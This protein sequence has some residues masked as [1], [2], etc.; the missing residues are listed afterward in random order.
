MSNMWLVLQHFPDPKVRPFLYLQWK[1]PRIGMKGWF[2]LIFFMVFLST[3]AAFTAW[4]IWSRTSSSTE[5]KQEREKKQIEYSYIVYGLLV[6]IAFVGMYALNIRPMARFL[7]KCLVINRTIAVI[8]NGELCKE[9]T[10]SM[11][12]LDKRENSDESKRCPCRHDLALS[13]DAYVQLQM[14]DGTKYEVQGYTKL[15]GGNDIT[16]V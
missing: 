1:S 5:A 2:K 12:S 8:P 10:A 11:N 3:L 4:I 6:L 13:K 15:E 14:V 9:K 7:G 16:M